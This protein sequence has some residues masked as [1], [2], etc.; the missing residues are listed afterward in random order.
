HVCDDDLEVEVAA[1]L[2]NSI[3]HLAD[4]LQEIRVSSL[5][6]VWSDKRNDRRPDF[7]VLNFVVEERFNARSQV[8]AE[9]RFEGREVPEALKAIAKLIPGRRAWPGLQMQRE[10]QPK[11]L[12]QRTSA[13]SQLRA[14][15][16]GGHKPG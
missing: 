2:S 13:R 12:V 1:R 15:R 6:S 7:H 3:S 16:F 10:Q 5:V 4:G 14:Q 9:Q 8:V 11:F